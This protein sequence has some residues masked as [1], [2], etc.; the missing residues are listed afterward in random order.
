MMNKKIVILSCIH[1]FFSK[2]VALLKIKKMHLLYG[3]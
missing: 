3:V 2:S 1:V